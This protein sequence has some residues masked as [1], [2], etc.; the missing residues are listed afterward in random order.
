MSIEDFK[1]YEEWAAYRETLKEQP[2]FTKPKELVIARWGRRFGGY[3]VDS[4]LLSIPLVFFMFQ[5]TAPLLAGLQSAAIDPVTGQ[6]DQAAMQDFIASM[7][8]LQLQ[9]YAI[10]AGVATVY[11]VVFHATMGQTLGKMLV[12][13]KVVRTDGEDIGWSHAIKRALINPIVQIVPVIGGLIALLNGLWPLW[14]EKRQTIG[15]KIAGT[16]VVES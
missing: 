15:D 14:D 9:M 1:M 3:L 7:M 16:M 13:V 11:Y 6:P 12:G 5:A 8:P 10:F 4:I 2:V